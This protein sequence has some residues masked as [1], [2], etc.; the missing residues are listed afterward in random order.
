M[1]NRLRT[2]HLEGKLKELCDGND[3]VTLVGDSI[4]VLVNGLASMYGQEVKQHVRENQW[5]VYLDADDEGND[6]GE[7]QINHHLMNTDDVYLF[8]AVQGSSGRTGQIILGVI[9]IVV[10]IIV[11]YGSWGTMT[12]AAYAEM[13]K[14]AMM[15]VGGIST[16]YTAMT[17]P[18]NQDLKGPEE[19][20]SFIFNGVANVIEQGGAVPCVY[21]RFRVGSTVVSAGIEAGQVGYQWRG[22][23]GGGGGGSGGGWSGGG[24]GGCVTS[25]S[26]IGG[27]GIASSVKVGDYLDVIN[28]LSYEMHKGLV[29]RADTVPQPC[30]RITSESGATLECSTT[31]P[32]ADRYGYQVLAPSLCGVVVPVI[33]DGIVKY[34]TVVS[35]EDIGV[36]DVVYITCENNFFLAGAT[37]GTYFLHHNIKS[38]EEQQQWFN[39]YYKT[40]IPGMDNFYV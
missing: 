4:P 22:G 18:K 20:A 37:E 10:G 16:I 21:G 8:P 12:P 28:P 19:K 32:I 9:M 26:M 25:G 14:G 7:N 36:K 29:T 33:H 39:D 2:I 6:I 13:A 27:F 24:G 34:E 40:Q 38:N 31:A 15:I 30:V 17:M 1:N 11:I 5:H 23:G 35:V 3:T